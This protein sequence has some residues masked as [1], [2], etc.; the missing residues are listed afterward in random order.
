MARKSKDWNYTEE[1][2]LIDNY[3][4]LT[5]K[6]L[7]GMFP[8]RSADSINTKI[9]RLKASGKIKGTKDPDTVKRS[10]DQRGDE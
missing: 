5:I 3:H 1:K 4:K 10:Y 9:K 8:N 6:E 2:V 7:R